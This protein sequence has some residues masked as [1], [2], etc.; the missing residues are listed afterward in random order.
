MSLYCGVRSD[1]VVAEDQ[2]A[3][4]VAIVGK[5]AV[6][7]KIV[8]HE[9][10]TVRAKVFRHRPCRVRFSIRTVSRRLDKKDVGLICGVEKI[11][12]EDAVNGIRVERVIAIHGVVEVVVVDAN[13]SRRT[14][15]INGSVGRG[16]GRW[17]ERK[18][19]QPERVS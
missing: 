3:A 18:A 5:M 2:A 17:I 8:L 12:V 19:R 7:E 11:V 4:E 10:E 1:N 14:V 15:D 9:Q 6:L 16:A 13:G